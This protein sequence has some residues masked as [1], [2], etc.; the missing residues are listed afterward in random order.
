MAVDMFLCLEGIKGETRDHK[1]KEEI[2][3]L[4]WSWGVSNSGSAHSGGGI[5]TG[6]ANFGDISVTKFFDKSTPTLMQLCATGKHIPKGKLIVRKAGE[7]PMDYVTLHMKDIMVA[8][9]SH[10]GSGHDDKL[11]EN[12]GL[13]FAE[14][15][16]EYT[17]QNQ[18][19][20]KGATSDFGYN[21]AENQRK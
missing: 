9:L 3:V 1:Y 12:L 2:E 17:V 19:G 18:D 8:S 21:I 10:G 4:S 20:S 5:G 15:K 16:I 11:T 13:N 6:K 7:K 14:F